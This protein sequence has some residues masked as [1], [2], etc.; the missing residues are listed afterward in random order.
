MSLACRITVANVFLIPLLLYPNRHF[1]YAS[2]T[3]A[4]RHWA[5]SQCSNKDENLHTWHFHIRQENIRDQNRTT[6]REARERRITPFYLH[7]Q[8]IKLPHDK[9]RSERKSNRGRN[10]KT[11][12]RVGS[13]V[14]L[15]QRSNEARSPGHM[16]RENSEQTWLTGGGLGNPSEIRHQPITR[17]LYKTLQTSEQQQWES[18]L[19]NRIASKGLDTGPFM[20][21]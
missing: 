8:Q 15:L 18:Y 13:G 20:S 7:H 14:R 3:F 6:R 10:D 2:E 11:H 21:G 9:N 19:L 12:P 4:A 17:W 1:F 5:S 16:Q